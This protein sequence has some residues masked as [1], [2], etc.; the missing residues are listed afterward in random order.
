VFLLLQA[1]WTAPSRFFKLNHLTDRFP[2]LT[3]VFSLHHLEVDSQMG[4]GVGM[5]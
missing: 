3:S 5:N 4:H 1:A 2:V